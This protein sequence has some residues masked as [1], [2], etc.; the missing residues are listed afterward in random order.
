MQQLKNRQSMNSRATAGATDPKVQPPKPHHPKDWVSVLARYRE[1]DLWRSLFELAV[2]LVPFAALWGLAWLALAH[3]GWLAL[4]IAVLN[5]GFLV[6]LFA[7]QHD[8]GHASFFRNRQV[9]DWVGRAI[10]VLTLT[11]YDVWR[12]THSIHHADAGN[13]DHR[14]MGDVQTLT[15]A[16][17]FDRPWC[18]RLTYR[19]YRNPL[20]LFGLGPLYLF[21]LQNRLPVGLMRSG[22]SYWVSAMATNL[23]I[24][25]LVGVILWFGG[26]WALVLIF[27]P[28]SL[29]AASVG[30][31][32]FFVQHQFEETYWDRAADWQVHDAALYGASHYV[33]PAPLR[34]ITAN[35]GVH[36][37]HHLYARIPFYRLMQVLRDHPALDGAQRM[38]LR[39]SLNCVKLQLW[40]ERGRKLLTYRQAR[41]LYP[42]A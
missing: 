18:G 40:D 22:W 21:L 25:V 7:I 2:T 41:A 15:V 36:H 14:G 31:W 16:E 13:L 5:G 20:V 27:L 32:L 42:V 1:P 4:A 8:C 38:T 6:R 10:G 3:S 35:I 37:V 28:T 12:R 26:I 30:V 34:W 9:G 19:L 24:A 33:L 11:P 29:V 17:F 23:A 39:Q